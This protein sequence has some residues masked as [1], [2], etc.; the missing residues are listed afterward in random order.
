M[1]V[2][3][4]IIGILIPSVGVSCIADPSSRIAMNPEKYLEQYEVVFFGVITS[5]ENVSNDHQIVTFD[6]EKMFKGE[7]NDYYIVDNKLSGTCSGYFDNAGTKYYVFANKTE[8]PNQVRL[9]HF[10]SFVSESMA[11]EFRMVLE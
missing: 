2:L 9:S 5:N 10:S 7:S 3:A 6:V 11:E 4:S 8:I 1:K